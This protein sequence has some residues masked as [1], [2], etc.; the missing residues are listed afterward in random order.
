MACGMLAGAGRARGQVI[1]L[2]LIHESGHGAATGILCANSPPSA[3][4]K[5]GLPHGPIDQ[6][7]F[8]RQTSRVKFDNGAASAVVARIPHRT[9]DLA[10]VPMPWF[11]ARADPLQT[12]FDRSPD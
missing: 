11:S 10:T 5:D 3:E 4:A 12:T 6:K 7:K 1:R 8:V 9:S 2:I